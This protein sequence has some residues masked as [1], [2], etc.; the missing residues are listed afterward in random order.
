MA[1]G[2]FGGGSKKIGYTESE[3]LEK[4]IVLTD[5]VIKKREVIIDVP[6]VIIKEVE[7]ERPII[8]DKEYE[9]PIIKEVIKEM[10]KFVPVEQETIRYVPKVV[11][12]EK[13]IIVTKEYEKPKMVRGWQEF[14]F[15]IPCN[16]NLTDE[17]VEFITQKLN[18]FLTK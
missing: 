9:R 6:K 4:G 11:E 8:K 17:E 7:Y 13:P 1:Q 16:E 2:V 5:V 18:E 10:I 3:T 15:R 14:A 12:C